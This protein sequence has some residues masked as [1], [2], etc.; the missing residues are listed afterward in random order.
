MVHGRDL[1]AAEGHGKK[2]WQAGLKAYLERGCLS[3][4][5]RQIMQNFMLTFM[6]RY[7]ATT[8]EEDS[9]EGEDDVEL[10]PCGA[11]AIGVVGVAGL[12]SGRGLFGVAL[13]SNLGGKRAARFTVEVQ[14]L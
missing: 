11:Q 10:Q 13:L 8:E 4:E 9:E 1:Q 7:S 14:W 6:V 12:Q 3:Q 5:I 2:S